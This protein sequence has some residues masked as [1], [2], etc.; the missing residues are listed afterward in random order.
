MAHGKIIKNR[1]DAVLPHDRDYAL[2]AM[3]MM[4]A[5]VTR[6]M[7]MMLVFIVLTVILNGYLLYQFFMAGAVGA[8]LF[9]GSVTL[10]FVCYFVY[11]LVRRIA[12][13]QL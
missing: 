13:G 11:G 5:I 12:R 2:E 3:R 6:M 7:W 1:D 10:V 8:S 4:S 9:W